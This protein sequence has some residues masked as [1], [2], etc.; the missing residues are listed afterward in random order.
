MGF[1]NSITSMAGSAAVSTVKSYAGA[2]IDKITSNRHEL[3]G[4]MSVARRV[5][6]YKNPASAIKSEAS[7]VMDSVGRELTDT[8]MGSLNGYV[9]GPLSSITSNMDKVTKNVNALRAIASMSPDRIFR[10]ES[11]KLVNL[12]TDTINNRVMSAADQYITGPLENITN[13]V[14]N[15]VNTINSISALAGISPISSF[16]SLQ[17]N[18]IGDVVS[19]ITGKLQGVA[20]GVM[21]GVPDL[22]SFLP[23][24]SAVSGAMGALSKI[25]SLSPSRIAR[26]A[27]V[28]YSAD[29]T[30]QMNQMM[31]D[32][33]GV[34][35]DGM[36]DFDFVMGNM[37]QL[38]GMMDMAGQMAGMNPNA[39]LGAMQQQVM[40][41]MKT[42]AASAVSTVKASIPSI[43]SLW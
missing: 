1:I 12:A 4:V 5:V 11:Q 38:E 2:G 19:G 29:M 3:R 26:R 34:F 14:D 41:P 20:D 13:N 21:G 23:N 43:G 25:S 36:Q 7:R 17:S 8:V 24:M 30:K 22:G 40:A 16:R 18:I 32:T 33:I 27:A 9:E 6:S 31:D 39:A 28:K 35:A 37:P 10:Q 42:M 15:V